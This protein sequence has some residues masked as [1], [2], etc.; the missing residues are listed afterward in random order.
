MWVFY[1]YSLRWIMGGQALYYQGTYL[2][3]ADVSKPDERTTR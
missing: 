3:T 2:Y 1:I